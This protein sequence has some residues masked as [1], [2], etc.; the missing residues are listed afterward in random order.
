MISTR[1]LKPKSSIPNTNTLVIVPSA[2][3][4]TNYFHIQQFFQ[5][6][7]KIK[8]F[9][10]LFAFFQF[11]PVLSKNGKVNYSAGSFFFTITRSGCLA[12]IRWSVCISKSQRSLCVSF[13]R[14]DSVL[15]IYHLFV[16]S[17]LNFLHNSQWITLP[18]ESCLFLCSLCANLLH[19]LIMW[20]ILLALSKHS[21][22]L[23][24]C[25]VLS[26]LALA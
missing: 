14:M 3:I 12:E 6:S 13:S 5:F 9:I 11:N 4:T 15:W 18:T 2:P 25:C 7:W 23:Q 8:V 24:F 19:S 21:L 16:W 22:P 17:N 1:P 20:L 10:S 26:I